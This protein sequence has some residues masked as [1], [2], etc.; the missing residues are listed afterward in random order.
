MQHC[1]IDFPPLFCAGQG[2]CK[3]DILCLGEAKKKV[4]APEM[5][6]L[7]FFGRRKKVTGVVVCGGIRKGSRKK[8]G[9]IPFRHFY[10]FVVRESSK[11]NP[12]ISICMISVYIGREG[13]EE[14]EKAPP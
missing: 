1:K 10:P 6:S 2:A 9:S 8:I 14:E 7:F 4:A 3:S 12:D 5:K 11:K 13:G